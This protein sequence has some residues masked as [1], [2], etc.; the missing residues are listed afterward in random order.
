MDN[1]KKGFDL[2][3]SKFFGS[4]LFLRTNEEITKHKEFPAIQKPYITNLKKYYVMM[5]HD[6]EHG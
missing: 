4:Y 3:L 5:E 6:Y 2:I 1:T